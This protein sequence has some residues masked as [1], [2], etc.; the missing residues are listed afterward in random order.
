MSLAIVFS[1]ASVGIHALQVT[2][3][4]HLSSGLPGFSI[5][6]LP[7]AVVKESKDRVRSAIINSGFEFPYQRTTVNL[8]PADL[9]KEGGRFDLPIAIGILLATEQIQNKHIDNYEFAGELALSGELRSF[10]GA[11][12]FS[13]AT[14]QAQRQLILPAENAYEAALPQKAIVLPAKHLLAICAHL[15]GSTL[16]KEYVREE[17]EETG[18]L[19]YPIDLAEVRGQERAKRALII[20]AAGAHGLLMMG[21]PGTGK[22]MLAS[23]LPTLLPPLN[24]EEALEV[25]AILSVS[26]RKF[27]VNEWRTRPFRSPHH[28][29]SGVA[30]VGGGRPPRPGE[31]SLAHH[32]VLFLDELPE[33]NRHVLET[34]REPLE[35][36][37]ITI[38]RAA[39]QAEFPARFQ[40][41]AAM[42]PCPCG[43]YGSKQKPCRCT[44]EQVQRYKQ[45]ISGPFLD[46]I[47]LQVEVL[48][49]VNGHLINPHEVSRSSAFI[50]EQVIQVRSLQLVRQKKINSRLSQKEMSQ[51]CFLGESEKDLFE[52]A[53]LKLQ[54]SARSMY[55]VLRVARTIADLSGEDQIKVDHLAEALSYRK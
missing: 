33:F 1:R 36:G 48:E 4:V 42:N 32:G 39:Q 30:L 38:S 19:E 47:D 16:L 53:S 52:E 13:L 20:A 3:E 6:G 50:R 31:I 44:V 7:E 18:F 10:T 25:A 46:R 41:V 2:V 29:A 35:S 11:L 37:V 55:R 9:P 8:A 22:T 34:L 26:G 15:Q 27:L 43:Y 21:P 14:R 49:Q 5:V 51:F 54:L 28:T 24:E 23:R 40:L 12:N 45:K 17:S